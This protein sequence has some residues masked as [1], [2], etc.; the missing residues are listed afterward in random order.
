MTFKLP[1]R[2]YSVAHIA[3]TERR[4]VL[5]RGLLSAALAAA[6]SGEGL[7]APRPKS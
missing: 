3:T 2:S 6:P 4:P 5:L 7:D 1:A